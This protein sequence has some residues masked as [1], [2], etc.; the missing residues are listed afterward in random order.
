MAQWT[1]QFFFLKSVILPST[2]FTHSAL[3]VFIHSANFLW[4]VVIY[5]NFGELSVIAWKALMT[6]PLSSLYLGLIITP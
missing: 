6:I 1:E 3:F 2:A 4:F 5:L